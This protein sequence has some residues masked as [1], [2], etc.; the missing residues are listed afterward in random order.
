MQELRTNATWRKFYNEYCEVCGSEA[1]F[2]KDF[3]N[4]ASSL[5]KQ[6]QEIK[7]HE[8]MNEDDAR[9]HPERMMSDSATLIQE[10]ILNTDVLI[11]EYATNA[12][13]W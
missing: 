2:G 10:N 7:L 6:V 1:Q 13:W 12:T 9:S 4:Y 3:N 8:Q 11:A 5:E